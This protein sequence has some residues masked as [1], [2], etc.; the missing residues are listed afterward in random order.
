MDDLPASA[1][2][3]PKLDALELP[4]LTG[5]LSGTGGTIKQF[6]E[7]FVVEEI[8]AYEPVGEGEHLFLWIEK[9]DVS[10]EALVRHVAAALGIARDHV[11][12]AGLKDRRA[13]T[14]QYLSV[15]A[16]CDDRLKNVD[17]DGIRVVRSRRHRHKLRTGHVKGNCF[18]ALIRGPGKIEM[19]RATDI[20]ARI[21]SRGFP[22][23]FGTQ[24]FGRDRENLSMGLKLISGNMQARDFP[25][26]RRKFL[27]RMSISAVQSF[28]FNQVLAER[29]RKGSLDWLLA[30]DVMQVTASGGNFVAENVEAEQ[31]RLEAGEIAVTGPIF[32]PKMKRPTAE[33][34]LREARILDAH[35]LRPDDFAR[36]GRLSRGTRRP[37]LVRPERLTIEHDPCGLRLRFVLPSGTYATSL[38]RELTKTVADRSSSAAD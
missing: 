16:D 20:A 15:P 2:A 4:Y 30:G 23:Y 8:P 3:E 34:A 38:L 10:A 22:N 11:G 1:G 24:R 7:D 21:I 14:R 37:F 26:S 9:R 31:P 19:Q 33:P 35:G 28:L 12:V 17:T 29:L 6:P 5:D 27:L 25:R 36:F 32:G 13:V 18:S